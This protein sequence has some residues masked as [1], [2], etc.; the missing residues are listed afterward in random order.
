MKHS[1]DPSSKAQASV[2][3]LQI[4]FD[5]LERRGVSKSQ[6]LGEH[7]LKEY[8][9]LYDY[10]PLK[11]IIKYWQLAEKALEYS[12]LGLDAG[13]GIQHS[14]LGLI[15]YVFMNCETLREVRDMNV[16]YQPLFTNAL[17]TEIIEIDETISASRLTLKMVGDEEARHLVELELSSALKM[18]RLVT[19]QD[20]LAFEA[21][22]FKHAYRSDLAEY[23]DF[24]DCE[25][26]FS[27]DENQILYKTN[28]L[29]LKVVT[30][31]L[32]VKESLVGHLD[33]YFSNEMQRRGGRF[34]SELSHYL[35]A[36]LGGQL[37]KS[38]EAAKDFGM[39]ASS[40]SR[41]LSSEGLS[42]KKVLTGIRMS[43]AEKLLGSS[44]DPI[45]VIS[46]YLDFENPSSFT[47]AFKRWSGVTPKAFRSKI[48]EG[49]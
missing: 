19:A 46:F 37:P 11:N 4:L 44:K 43:S 24:F 13:R 38:S 29:D 2:A 18:I 20:D 42:Y 32:E 30:P 48:R 17:K 3:Y 41:A 39:S 6:F 26:L 35:K 25:V 14:D 33:R 45:D 5:A 28:M 12:A 21:V 16:R 23:I 27:Q 7:Q 36:R 1:S 31:N 47:R 8:E 22:H 40:M 10:W 9:Y 34:S 49:A 15:I